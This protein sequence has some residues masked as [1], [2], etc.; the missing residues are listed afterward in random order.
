MDDAGGRSGP[1][2]ETGC[3]QCGEPPEEAQV[4]GADVV[5][6]PCGH[7][8]TAMSAFDVPPDVLDGAEE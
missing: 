3:P 1:R 4:R 7:S 5:L 2:L 6:V 8:F